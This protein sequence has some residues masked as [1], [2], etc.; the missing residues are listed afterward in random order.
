M[1]K[2]KMFV[3]LLAV[4]FAIPVAAQQ[5]VDV[6]SHIIV[7]EYMEMLKRHNA[8]LEETFPLPRWSV[9]RHLQFMDSMGIQTSVLTMPAPQ[10]FYGDAEESARCVRAVNERAAQVKADFPGRFLFCASLPLP[11]VDAAIRE[12]IY[13]LDT[14]RA[15]GIKL[16]TNSRGQYLGDEE[17]D[18]LMEV[19]D[20]RHAV[21]VIHPHRPTPYPEKVVETTPLAMY[22]Y[23]AETTRAVV[24]M[25]ARNVLVRYP[26]LKVVVPHCGS[27][28]PLALPRMRSIHPAMQAGGFMAPIDWEG[29]LLRLYYDLAGNP[30]PEVL[31]ALLTITTPGHILYGSDY[32]Y[33]ADKV[34]RGNLDR[35][36]ATLAVEDFAPCGEM[37][38]GG[39]ARALF[40]IQEPFK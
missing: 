32:P 27:F 5:I 1:L 33:L 6:H 17:L 28:L 22:E 21:I 24:N 2:K 18:L 31:R 16:A 19:L 29:N 13:A 15:D 11:D 35:L 7:P 39:N 37:F 30:A 9:E 23:P 20:E 10:P 38:L 25:I 34:L 4:A 8:E 12:A 3:G 14:L 40:G 26:N 36:K